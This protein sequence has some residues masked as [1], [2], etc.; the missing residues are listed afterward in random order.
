MSDETEVDPSCA[1]CERRLLP[2]ERLLRFV[3]REGP[4]RLGLHF[5]GGR[6]AFIYASGCGVPRLAERVGVCAPGRLF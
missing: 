5:G 3:T 6:G 2:G 1:V 4:A